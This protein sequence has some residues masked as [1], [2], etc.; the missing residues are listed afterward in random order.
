MK[1]CTLQTEN[2]YFTKTF[3]VKKRQQ[4][5]YSPSIMIMAVIHGGDSHNERTGILVVSLRGVNFGF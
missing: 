3:F 2:R 5:F 4:P 1:I